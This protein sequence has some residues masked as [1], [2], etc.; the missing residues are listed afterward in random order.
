MGVGAQPYM[1]TSSVH[2]VPMQETP[3]SCANHS[4]QVRAAL[5]QK[6]N[7]HNNNDNGQTQE[8]EEELSCRV[9]AQPYMT[10]FSV[11]AAPMHEIPTSCANQSQQVR[12]ALEQ[13][14]NTNK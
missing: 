4:Q 9:G 7:I 10:T 14:L 2:A 5:E 6:M 1:T 3:T 13:K 8:G 12:A 11:H